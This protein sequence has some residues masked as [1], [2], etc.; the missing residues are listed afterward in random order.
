[1]T[2][3]ELAGGDDAGG[4]YIALG[5]VEPTDVG[6]GST[7]AELR[8]HLKRSLSKAVPFDESVEPSGGVAI[9]HALCRKAGQSGLDVVLT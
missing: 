3:S 5:V 4:E 1:M 9:A 6:E 8:I 2:A 7:K